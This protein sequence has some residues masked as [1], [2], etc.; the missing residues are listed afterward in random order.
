MSDKCMSSVSPLSLTASA[1]SVDQIQECFSLAWLSYYISVRTEQII[2]G[3]TSWTGNPR[4]VGLFP[5]TSIM[6]RD[7]AK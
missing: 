2:M 7:H 1:I 5:V 6:L 3:V 4:N